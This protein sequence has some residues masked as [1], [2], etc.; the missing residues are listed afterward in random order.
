MDLQGTSIF[1]SKL[2]FLLPKIIASKF[3]IVITFYSNLEIMGE[4]GIFAIPSASQRNV[5]F[6]GFKEHCDGHRVS[7]ELTMI[8]LLRHSHPEF[9]ITCS[10]PAKCDLFGY[11]KAGHATYY[12]DSDA[13]FDL[14]RSYKAPGPRLEGKPGILKDHVRFGRWKYVWKGYEFLLY[15]VEYND[16]VR[17]PTKLY[18]I[19][20]LRS[21]DHENDDVSIT[22]KLLLAVGAWS[23]E[24]HEEIYVFDD[25][26]WAKNHDLWSSVQGAS[27]DE[28]ILNP[29]MK[30][31]LIAD[32]Q[33]F[34]DNR[35][36]Y[37]SLAVPW[38]RGLILH[39]VPGNGKTIS[40]KALINALGARP[41]P[42]P[43]LYVKS[44]DGCQGQK[45]S[46]R[47]IFSQA[48]I[49]APCLLIFE[50]LDSLVKDETRS[51]FL[52]EVDGLESNDGILMIGSTNHLDSL[53]PAISK[54]PSRFD[55]KYHFKIPNEDERAAYC[56]FWRRKLVDNSMVDFNED[57]CRIIAKLS[58]GF[59][60][61]YLKELFVITL[62]TIARGGTVEQEEEIQ[63]EK[64]EDAK[65]SI[66]TEPIMVEHETGEGPG[67]KGEGA[68]VAVKV[69][70]GATE[71]PEEEEKKK[72]V[73]PEVE[74]PEHL[75]DNVLLKVVRAQL[76]MLLDEMDNTKEEDW[77]S[78]KTPSGG[79]R[80]SRRVPRMVRAVPPPSCC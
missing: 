78:G 64:N 80:P 69:G 36:L 61:A 27:W 51:Y 53:D 46:I 31:N 25:G 26:Y 58:E 7:T 56:Q 2:H 30:S 79:S 23:T 6:E 13:A 14:T 55:R 5:V 72:R 73:L 71:K 60:F 21:E 68:E 52:N 19:L 9:N 59:S 43:S 44:F 4:H 67:A 35:G 18:F 57:L 76:K 22:D 47:L 29:D 28:V 15:E 74:T 3:N 24:L 34:F 12:M 49:M 39:G 38:K 70:A 48:R 1:T 20:F 37:K 16:V 40:I 10:T 54:R 63:E 11:A 32:V 17:M 65:S 33:G 77:P 62:L 42:V 66:S 50:D 45:Y 75:R 41:D 8:E